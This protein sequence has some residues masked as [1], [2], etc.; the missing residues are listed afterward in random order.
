MSK[1]SYV[2]KPEVLKETIELF[3]KDLS[4][5]KQFDGTFQDGRIDGFFFS[6]RLFDVRRL[7]SFVQIEG[8]Y[9]LE[10]GIL[11]IRLFRTTYYYFFSLIW[12]F[13]AIAGSVQALDSPYK[14]LFLFPVSL[15]FFGD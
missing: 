15:G 2:E 13:F 1:I 6:T 10:K 5:H 7:Y 4:R 9:N 11:T 14:L 3:L 12:L 8:S